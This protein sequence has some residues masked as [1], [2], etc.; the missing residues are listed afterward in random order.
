M[1][2][3]RLRHG[4]PLPREV[5]FTNFT[6]SVSHLGFWELFAND[7]DIPIRGITYDE[8]HKARPHSQYKVETDSFLDM[9]GCQNRV[10]I[11]VYTH[12]S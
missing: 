6:N 4:E 12:G 1:A 10:D 2:F 9:D 7:N 5:V 8:C 11:N 3:I